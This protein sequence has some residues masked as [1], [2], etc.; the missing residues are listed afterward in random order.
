MQTNAIKLDSY[1]SPT[2]L[3]DVI[4]RISDEQSISKIFAESS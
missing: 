3:A 4:R 2:T 1:P